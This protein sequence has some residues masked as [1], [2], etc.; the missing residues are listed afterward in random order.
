[1]SLSPLSFKN[2]S[3]LALPDCHSNMMGF[4]VNAT[5]L[6]GFSQAWVLPCSSTTSLPRLRSISM[7]RY[8]LAEKNL[9]LI[10]GAFTH[11]Q[12]GECILSL[13]NF[14]FLQ[15]D[16]CYGNYPLTQ[17]QSLHY[18]VF[19]FCCCLPP[20]TNFWQQHLQ[21]WGKCVCGIVSAL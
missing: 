20:H 17:S 15:N 12:F 7:K 19:M 13:N 8:V 18:Y 14:W 16:H 21:S 6:P 3:A 10:W 5:G 2:L 11:C 9:S 4:R 1:M